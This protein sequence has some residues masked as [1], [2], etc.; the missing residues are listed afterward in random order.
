MIKQK[1]NQYQI[2]YQLFLSHFTVI[3]LG[4]SLVWACVRPD[5][6]HVLKSRPISWKH[7]VFEI[8]AAW[9]FRSPLQWTRWSGM[10]IEPCLK[11]L[12]EASAHSN[13]WKVIW[14][15]A[16]SFYA[17]NDDR[18][19]CSGKTARSSPFLAFF[20]VCWLI[21]FVCHGWAPFLKQSH[22]VNDMGSS[23]W[24]VQWSNNQKR[25]LSEPHPKPV[26]HP[27]LTCYCLS[28]ACL[29]PTCGNTDPL[30]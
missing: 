10:K 29:C 3:S 13:Y 26:S 6:Q 20:L 17:L 27:Q 8:I 7:F 14:R 9:I 22:W 4:E 25:Q 1:V 28:R 16:V 23:V 24:G 15:L 30:W 19:A 12:L 11:F 21:H 2:A 18:M 5:I